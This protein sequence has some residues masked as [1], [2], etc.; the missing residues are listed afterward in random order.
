[1][2]WTTGKPAAKF[3]RGLFRVWTMK[4]SLPD[5]PERWESIKGFSGYMI[6]TLGR[7]K[8]FRSYYRRKGVTKLS[9]ISH[10]LKPRTCGG[11]DGYF[12]ITLSD[13]ENS[14][15]FYIHR[16]V[17]ETF[18]GPAPVGMECCHEDGV[19]HNCKLSNLYWGTRRQNSS[20]S[21]KHGTCIKGERVASSKLTAADVKNICDRLAS[22]QTQKSI[23][24][25]FNV[26]ATTICLIN[27]GKNWGW[28]TGRAKRRKHTKPLQA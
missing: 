17:L 15:Q 27:I 4:Y 5:Y 8:S 19:K 23:A 1:M 25:Y 2:T 9:C 26:A 6:S 18:I 24:A 3:L 10:I 20:D 11:R 14:G 16:L 7:V 12:F 28:L 13:G 21:I 22:G